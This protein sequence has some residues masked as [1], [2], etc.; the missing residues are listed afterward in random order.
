M[1]LAEL[2]TVVRRKVDAAEQARRLPECAISNKTVDQWYM[3]VAEVEAERAPDVDPH[4]RPR[5]R[6][7]E[8]LGRLCLG[9]TTA[10]VSW[11]PSKR[12]TFFSRCGGQSTASGRKNNGRS[13]PAAHAS[14]TSAMLAATRDPVQ[15]LLTEDS[16]LGALLHDVC[17]TG[18]P[19]RVVVADDSEL[20]VVEERR[21]CAHIEPWVLPQEWIPQVQTHSARNGTHENHQRVRF[22]KVAALAANAELYEGGTIYIDNDISLKR[23]H[24][25]E[26]FA[27]FDNFGNRSIGF[28]K[29]WTNRANPVHRIEGVPKG[30]PERNGGVC[31]MLGSEASIIARDWLDELAANPGPGGTDQMPLRRVLWRHREHL[32]DLPSLVQCRCR[33]ESICEN[34][35]LLWHLHRIYRLDVLRRAGNASEMCGFVP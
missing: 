3:I 6:E 34:G 4:T 21:P 35:A 25:K 14:R 17:A 30:F 31:F 10:Q 13:S 12:S 18:Y 2:D 16:E 1:H 20:A 11:R 8:G 29:D 24:T 15:A 26:L 19:C 28:N 32:F 27:V 23:S 5:G 33:K 22:H 7:E 9:P